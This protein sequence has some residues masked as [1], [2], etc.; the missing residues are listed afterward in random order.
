MEKSFKINLRVNIPLII[1]FLGAV[2]LLCV[3]MAFVRGLYIYLTG[4]N[5]E[6]SLLTKF[7]MDL[8]QT[9]PTYVSAINLF[10]ASAFLAL[11]AKSK[12]GMEDRYRKHWGALA[13]GFLLLSVDESIS[14]HEVV[15]A[16]FMMQLSA[17]SGPNHFG[18]GVLILLCA[19][20]SSM[21]FLKFILHLPARTKVRMISSGVVFVLGAAG[22]EA[23]GG[24]FVS[25]GYE[26]VAYNISVI[27]EES[28]E[29]A[30]ILLFIRSLLY[31]IQENLLN[32]SPLFKAEAPGVA[33]ELP[34]SS[35]NSKL[36]QKEELMQDF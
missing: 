35:V 10:I 17:I 4:N 12:W 29:M 1:R 15:V 18:A 2:I 25:D 33:N 20:L 3:F 16:N 23:I 8:E 36:A 22:M 6:D 31:Y 28:L 34:G 26:K 9:L 19:A 27:I 14:L 13:L 5:A 30:G 11:I 21:L 32:A 7:N 24:Y